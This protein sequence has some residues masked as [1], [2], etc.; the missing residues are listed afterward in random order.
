MQMRKTKK[1]IGQRAR[2]RLIMQG[3]PLPVLFL[4]T[5]KFT[6]A[7]GHFEMPNNSIWHFA[8]VWYRKFGFGNLTY[9]WHFTYLGS[10]LSS[11]A[12][13]FLLLYDT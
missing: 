8:V 3:C 2:A 6:V 13:L 7:N 10:K 12:V 4:F 5:A 9:F 11:L 1:A